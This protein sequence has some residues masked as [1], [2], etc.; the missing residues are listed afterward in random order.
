MP[1]E[2]VRDN[3]THMT[4]D[5][6]DA[7]AH[8]GIQAERAVRYEFDSNNYKAKDFPLFCSR[9]TFTDDSVMTLAVAGGLM[10][11]PE[12]AEAVP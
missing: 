9:S 8:C 5:A 1:F 7:A 11:V 12:G 2:I 6:I 10:N 3:I 4:T